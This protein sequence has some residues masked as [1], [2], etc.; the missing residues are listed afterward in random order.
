MIDSVL[1]SAFFDVLDRVQAYS[2]CAG[3]NKENNVNVRNINVLNHDL[4]E[5]YRSYSIYDAKGLTDKINK[6]NQM[7]DTLINEG[8]SSLKRDIASLIKDKDSYNEAEEMTVEIHT[9]LRQILEKQ[10]EVINRLETLENKPAYTD[11]KSYVRQDNR[12]TA[13]IVQ[14]NPDAV[15]PEDINQI[16]KLEP[17]LRKTITDGRYTITSRILYFIN[18][19]PIGWKI[20]PKVVNVA[21]DID[22][23]RVAYTKEY[24]RKLWNRGY[25]KKTRINNTNYYFVDEITSVKLEKSPTAFFTDN[26]ILD[27]FKNSEQG[28]VLMSPQIA[29]MLGAEKEG[30]QRSIRDHLLALYNKGIL[31]RKRADGT[32][33]PYLYWL[34]E[35]I[36]EQEATDVSI[37]P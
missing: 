12:F 37:T 23:Q 27:I 7:L 24:M 31:D 29:A 14:P 33:K 32:G 28:T 18:H 30:E 9:S 15:S 34:K 11:E 4:V 35:P 25:L 26:P 17:E 19:L 22:N 3:I 10:T 8:N 16:L 20:P 36:T 13:F 2:L 5:I 6:M 1:K 21:L